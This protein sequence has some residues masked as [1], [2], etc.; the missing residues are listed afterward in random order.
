MPHCRLASLPITSTNASEGKDGACRRMRPISRSSS[1]TQ[2]WWHGGHPRGRP[3]RSRGSAFRSTPCRL[4]ALSADGQRR[5]AEGQACPGTRQ[6]SLV[7]PEADDPGRCVVEYS[8]YT[9]FGER[10]FSF[11]VECIY[12]LGP[13]D[14]YDVE[15]YSKRPSPVLGREVVAIAGDGPVTSVSFRRGAS[16]PSRTALKSVRSWWLSAQSWTARRRHARS[17]RRLG[18]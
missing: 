15:Y 5:L 16:K 8:T 17:S 18:R 7:N 6:S 1:P 9:R 2:G 13:P 10:V 3:H 11:E 12:G 14:T 4:Q